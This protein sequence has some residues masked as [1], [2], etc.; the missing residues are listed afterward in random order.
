MI[1]GRTKTAKKDTVVKRDAKRR[2]ADEDYEMSHRPSQVSPVHDLTEGGVIPKDIYTHPQYYADM[3]NKASQESFRV[4]MRVRGKP[5]SSI[6]I[7]RAS[8]VKE[9][10]TGDWVSLSRTY[11]KT[12]SQEEGVPAHSFKVKA[13]DVWFAGDDVNEFGYWGS[14]VVQDVGRLIY[15]L[16]GEKRYIL[17]HGKIPPNANLLEYRK[18]SQYNMYGETT[19][20][21]ASA[22]YDYISDII[23]QLSKKGAKMSRIDRL[24]IKLAPRTTGDRKSAG[25]FGVPVLIE[26]PNCPYP[27]LVN[28][29]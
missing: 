23:E 6:T 7:Y 10:N 18:S 26:T 29:C 2:N 5:N 20:Q 16:E 11:A 27:L 25:S 24:K 28:S 3:S 9:L 8:P 15:D 21:Q 4:I 12:E 22:Y 14:P 13:K 17:K 1:K 19:K